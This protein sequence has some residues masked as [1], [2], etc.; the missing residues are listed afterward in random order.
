MGNDG[1]KKKKKKISQFNYD[2]FKKKSMII[3][4]NKE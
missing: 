2:I 4:E 1:K 3:I